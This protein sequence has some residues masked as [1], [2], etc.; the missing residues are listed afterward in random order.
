M[1]KFNYMYAVHTFYYAHRDD[2]LADLTDQ[3]PCK[4]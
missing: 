1:Q 3:P 4:R 2:L